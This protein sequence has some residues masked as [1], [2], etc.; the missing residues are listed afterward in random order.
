ML[1]WKYANDLIAFP[2]ETEKICEEQEGEK[3]KKEQAVFYLG[4][5]LITD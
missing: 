4:A 5:L 3:K 1:T 2:N